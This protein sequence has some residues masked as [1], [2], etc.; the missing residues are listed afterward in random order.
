MDQPEKVM[1]TTE[2]EVDDDEEDMQ[3]FRNLRLNTENAHLFMNHANGAMIH[4]LGPNYT[5][6]TMNLILLRKW[7]MLSHFVL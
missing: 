2:E 5:R 1:M 4:T 3:D 7:C 6:I